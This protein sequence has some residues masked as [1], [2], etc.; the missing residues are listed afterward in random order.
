MACG[1]REGRGTG[2]GHTSRD[3]VRRADNQAHAEK[4]RKAK[5]L[6]AADAEWR[7]E[8]E[9]AAAQERAIQAGIGYEELITRRTQR[10]SVKRKPCLRQTRNGVR[11]K[12]GPRHRSGPYKPGSGTKS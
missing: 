3:R 9:R 8:Q 12:R 6:L 10:R 1:T 2:A 5:A 11:N 4:I 7:A